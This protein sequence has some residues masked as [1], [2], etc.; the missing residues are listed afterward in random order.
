M[1]KYSSKF[2]L[3]GKILEDVSSSVKLEKC[4]VQVWFESVQAKEKKKTNFFTSGLP[5]EYQPNNDQCNLC[6]IK[7]IL[8]T[9]QRVY[10]FI[11]FLIIILF[12]KI[13]YL[14]Q[15][16]IENIRSILSK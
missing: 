11:S 6:Q 7:Y 5:G 1:S 2:N 9:S 10:Q 13:I 16:Y 4:V 3:L 12:L 15:K 8:Q 14:H